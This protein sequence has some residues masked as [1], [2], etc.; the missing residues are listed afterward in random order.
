MS[1]SQGTGGAGKSQSQVQVDSK[2]GGTSA[3]AQGGGVQH[4]SQSE[5]IANEK[6]G[7]A[8]AQ[9][10]GPGQTSSQ[11]QIGFRPESGANDNQSNIFNG[12]GQ[13]SAQSGSHS[14]QSQSQIHGSF[15]YGISY[16]G[17]AQA[18]SGT[19]EQV[20]TYREKNKKLFQDIGAFSRYK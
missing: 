1:S 9:G 5:V 12:G 17:A 6:G 11:A 16:H 14:G 10:S 20:A 2:T 18:A 7:L 3:T 8:D 4:S 15:K 19:K 13:A